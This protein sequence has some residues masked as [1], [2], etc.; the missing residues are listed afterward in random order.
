LRTGKFLRLFSGVAR[1]LAASSGNKTDEN[2]VLCPTTGLCFDSNIL[3]QANFSI[4]NVLPYLGVSDSGHAEDRFPTRLLSTPNRNVGRVTKQEIEA[5]V[6]EIKNSEVSTTNANL[7]SSQAVLAIRLCG[8]VLDQEAQQDRSKLVADVWNIILEKKVPLTVVH[9][10]ALLRVHL[11]NKCNFNP[12]TMMEEMQA[13][14]ILPDRETYQCFISSYCQEGNI[15]GASKILTAMKNQ[16][17][18]VNENIFNSLIIGH[19]R[20]GDLARAQGIIKVMRQCGLNPSTETYLTLACAFAMHGDVGSMDRIISESANSGCSFQDGDYLELLFVLCESNHK[21]LVGKVMNDLHPATE[22]FGGLASHLTV[23]LVNAGHDDVAYNLVQFTVENSTE[24]SGKMI[25]IEFLEQLVRRNTTVSK[26]LWILR[27]MSERKIYSGGLEKL[28]DLALENENLTLALKL[29]DILAADGGKISKRQ[30][31]QMLMLSKSAEDTGIK[32][33][34]MFNCIKIGNLFNY[35][36]S[37]MLKKHIFPTMMDGQGNSWPELVIAQLEEFGV[38]RSQTVTAMIEYLVGHGQT[39]A[40]STVAG[41][42][43][44]HVDSKLKFMASTVSSSVNAVCNHFVEVDG[45]A[46]VKKINKCDEQMEDKKKILL[47]GAAKLSSDNNINDLEAMLEHNQDKEVRSAVYTHLINLYATHKMIDRAINLSR[48]L[49]EEQMKVPEFYEILGQLIE[50]QYTESLTTATS[51]QQQQLQH[52]QPPTASTPTMPPMAP[53]MLP[54]GVPYMTEAGFT[55]YI[56]P[57]YPDFS[58]GYYPTAVYQPMNTASSYAPSETDVASSYPTTPGMCTPYPVAMTPDTVYSDN[59]EVSSNNGGRTSVHSSVPGEHSYLH[60]QLKRL[61]IAGEPDNALGVYRALESSGKV[62]NV[63]ET[64]SLIE[65]LVR[66]DMM[67]EAVEVTQTMLIRNMHPIPKIFRFL[68]NKLASLGYV[69]DINTI[70][71]F[72]SSK[73]KKDVSYDNRLCNAYLS[74]G[75][76]AEFLTILMHDLDIALAVGDSDQMALLQDRFPRGGAMGLLDNHPELLDSFTRLAEKFARTGYIAPMNVLWTYHFI[77]ENGAVADTIWQQYVKSSNQIMFQKVCQVARSTGNLN[78]AF[79]LVAK[80][81]DADQVTPGARG[82]AYSCLLDCLAA[83]HQHAQ[84][85]TVLKDALSRGIKL[86]DVNR[87]ALV[88]LKSGLEEM[89]EQ[90]PYTIPPK[91]ATANRSDQ[92]RSLS[93]LDWSQE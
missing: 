1:N 28:L 6:S 53:H 80:L 8:T 12:E 48:R 66:Y 41:I 23:R 69:E 49:R 30:F 43:S 81:Q 15:E 67:S 88:R 62:V 37:G 92:E 50:S 63:T 89:G 21:D 78:L 22:Q 35:V 27:D 91:N 57:A 16:G 38:G 34:A 59:N 17:H 45:I 75:R 36:N 77:N 76:G 46:N 31:K 44:E 33:E 68:L 65:Q 32:H 24:E 42:F 74:A 4:Q 14:S 55:G 11:E 93:P 71:N 52:Q 18:A 9:Y 82:I 10:N 87:T 26:L 70:G 83:G 86:E 73:I 2:G 25:S 58:N 40:A 39:E 20:N 72:L 13:Q 90:F 60:R 7:L 5:I 19:S 56:Y 79:G 61:V 85:Y 84:G 29:S 47:D 64:S 51:Q 3:S 54:M